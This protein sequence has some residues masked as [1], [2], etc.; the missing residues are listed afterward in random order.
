MLRFFLDGHFLLYTFINESM[1][2][3]MIQIFGKRGIF[4]NYRVSR[5]LYDEKWKKYRVILREFIPR[6]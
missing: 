2:S 4:E 3:S 1:F 6:P 5:E